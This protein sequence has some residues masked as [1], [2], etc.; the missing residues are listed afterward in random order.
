MG[1]NVLVD[2]VCVIFGQHI[3][4]LVRLWEEL[5]AALTS[6]TSTLRNVFTIVMES[7]R[8]INK[9]YALVAFF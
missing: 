3:K 2:E 4:I 7:Q 8:Q 6:T 1:E 9:N 5:E